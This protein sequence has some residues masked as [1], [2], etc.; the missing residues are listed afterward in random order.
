MKFESVPDN[1]LDEVLFL[2]K[3]TYEIRE[4]SNSLKAG[5]KGK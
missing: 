5:S 1:E 4:P 2:G 3:E